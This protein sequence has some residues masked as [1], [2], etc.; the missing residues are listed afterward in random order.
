MNVEMTTGVSETDTSDATVA[1][2]V[3]ATVARCENTDFN[4]VNNDS[5]ETPVVSRRDSGRSPRW[6]SRISPRPTTVAAT[7]AATI[8]IAVASVNTNVD[9][10]LT[11]G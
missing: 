8:V 7:V 6:F 1:T 11:A 3:A 10:H 5:V 9:S 2:T 4:A